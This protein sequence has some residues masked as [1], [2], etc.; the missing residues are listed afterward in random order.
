MHEKQQYSAAVVW[1]R[2]GP[3]MTETK[4]DHMTSIFEA[5]RSASPPVT[6]HHRHRLSA[7][8]AAAAAAPHSLCPF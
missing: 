6:N 1:L 8:A 7:A 2:L 5:S 4:F 3:R